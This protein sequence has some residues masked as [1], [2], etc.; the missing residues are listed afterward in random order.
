M[1][2]GAVGLANSFICT[3]TK[4]PFARR[5]PV[6]SFF[7]YIMQARED[8][9]IRTVTKTPRV[10][11]FVEL[12]NRNDRMIYPNHGGRDSDSGGKRT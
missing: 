11:G 12:R 7:P 10:P 9:V 1:T 6:C 5:I 4:R 8:Q 3:F 2:N